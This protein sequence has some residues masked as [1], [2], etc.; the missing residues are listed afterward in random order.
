M[1]IATLVLLGLALGMA[2]S[3]GAAEPGAPR[4]AWWKEAVIY[5]IYPRSFKDTNGDG[6][7]DLRGIVE[8]LDYLKALGVDVLWLCPIFKSPNADN[9][10]DVSDY[11]DI[12]T[13]FG[14]MKDFDDLIAGTRARNMKV[15]LDLVPNHSSDEHAWFKASR[16]S[17]DN[18]YRDYYFW[19]PPKDG[20]EPNNWRSYFSGPAWEMD[21]ATGEYYLHLFAKKQPDL[22]WDNPKVRREIQ[23]IM[24]FWLD[25]GIGGWR[26][27]V[28]PF[29]SK[30]PGLPDCPAG[31]YDLGRCYA[32]GP[33]LHEYVQE[34]NREVLSHY[35]AMTV[36]EGA[37]LT[38]EDGPLLVDERRHELSMIYHFD[39]IA[40]DRRRGTPRMPL[41]EFKAIFSRW[42]HALGSTGWVSVLLGNHD[43]PRM[44]SRFGDAG[45]GRVPSSKMLATLLLTMKGTPYIYQGDELG[46]TNTAFASI[47]D[48]DD[49]ETRNAYAEIQAQGGDTA[50]FLRAQNSSARDHAR[51]PFQWDDSPGA[52]FTAGKPWLKL[53][54]NYTAINARAQENDPDAPLAYFRRA[55]RFRKEHAPSLVYGSYEDL[56][57]ASSDVFA[58]ARRGEGE[59]LLVVL[60][61]SGK[62]ADYV[63]PKVVA[64]G[65]L[66]LGNYPAPTAEARGALRLRPWEARVYT[67]RT[68]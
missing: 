24:R 48:F 15:L 57:P 2:A 41:V 21:P 14:S 65:K 44:V 32:N 3:A 12:M 46:M 16:A 17:K 9:G 4:K 47:E 36:G 49:I 30:K 53:N 54:P 60:S 31:D 6:V 7:G 52:G 42:D 59:S 51:T 33:R 68:R 20:R 19:R 43:F 13:E 38:P 11:R 28:I 8:K 64:P 63:L 62:P 34:L 10:Y 56:D 23:D 5:Q 25:K 29:V 27:D 66:L 67:L 37:G 26:I 50:A 22:N 40:M 18:P 1:R 35:D 39:H 45:E 61:F 55:I 58:Y